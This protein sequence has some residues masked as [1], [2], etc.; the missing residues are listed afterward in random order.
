MLENILT[1]S[2]K[3]SNDDVNNYKKLIWIEIIS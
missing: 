1:R 3:H 2:F